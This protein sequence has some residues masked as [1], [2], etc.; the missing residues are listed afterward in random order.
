MKE[1][2]QYIEEKDKGAILITTG[3][4]LTNFYLSFGTEL[5]YPSPTN[6]NTMEGII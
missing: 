6:S 4:S 1:I 2:K 3:H 5:K